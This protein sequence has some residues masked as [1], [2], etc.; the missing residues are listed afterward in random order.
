MRPYSV[1]L[2]LQLLS[3]LGLWGGLPAF[4]RPAS[5]HHQGAGPTA[6]Q[7]KRYTINLDLPPLERWAEV[8][9]DYSAELPL[10]LQ[11]IKQ[12]VPPVAVD[13]ADIIG[14]GIEKYIPYPYNEELLGIKQNV[15]GIGLGEVVLGNIVY[16]VTAFGHGN[17]KACTS[18]VAEA[19]NGTIYHGRNLDYSFTD[20]LRNMTIICD[21]QSN[22]TTLYTGTTFAGYVGLLTGQKPHGFTISLDE[23]DQGDWWMNALE[24]LVAGTHGITSFFIRDT[25]G[26]PDMD[27]EKAVYALANEQAFIAPSYLIVGGMGPRQGAVIT[28]DRITALDVWM[29]DAFNGRW[30]L[31]ETNY[32]HWE[33][34]P[35]GDDRRDPAEKAMNETGRANI[36]GPALF[37]VLSTPP[38][39]NDG[40]SYTAI[41]SASIPGLYNTWIR[42]LN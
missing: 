12:M 1:F 33:P 6:Q 20:V 37:N 27:F 4:G 7:A 9:R 22:G 25:L 10:L 36:D 2:S 41:M 31:V 39:L 26:N 17:S 40:T 16:E 34:P 3:C 14:D 15:K 28:R 42:H 29:I 13:L 11:A 35:A 21:F 38:V 24:A 5:R 18:I 30:Y 32:D 23:R 19:E 8:T